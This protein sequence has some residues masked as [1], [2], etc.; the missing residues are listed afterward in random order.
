MPD[1]SSDQPSAAGAPLWAARVALAFVVLALAALVVVPMLMQQYVTPRREQAELA[2]SARTLVN[3]VQFA[4]A[5]EMS[6]LLGASVSGPDARYRSIYNDAWQRERS[7]YAK[8]DSLASNLSTPARQALA[9]LEERSELWHER[10]NEEAVLRQEAP[11]RRGLVG[12]ELEVFESALLAAGEL[13][14]AI[15]DAAQERRQDIR[16][17]EVFEERVSAAMAAFALL[18]AMTVGWFASRMR[19][20]AREAALRGAQAERALTETKRMAQSR[21]RIMRGIT[22]DLK[23][24][25]GAADGYGD[26]LQMGIAGE[27][28]PEQARMVDGM[29][30]SIATALALIAD[31][32]QFERADA[33]TL[34][35]ART[36]VDC[37]ALARGAAEQ[38]RGA[39][40]AAGLELSVE[41]PGSA[42]PAETD[43]AR[44]EQILSNL[45]SNAIKYTPPPG[46]VVVHVRTHE[47][48][49]A[50][51]PGRVEIC[52]SDSG[53]GIAP[54]DRERVFGEFERL[55]GARAEGY[56]LGL[57]TS[58]RVATQLGGDLTVGESEM[59]GA[60][61]SLWL[62]A[63]GTRERAG[64]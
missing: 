12:P 20:L 53:E 54:E 52:V 16:R 33:G 25:L 51:R 40:Q 47:S 8:L 24:P 34:Q 35:L 31:L 21:T 45:L 29:R 60:A 17:A 59:G 6:A 4:L 13:D 63:A 50:G 38:Y 14:R 15:L 41:L 61:F 32:L 27:L 55:P 43:A 10:V 9:R 56:G 36:P 1:R 23:N 19:V 57:A 58:R 64:A 37:T 3:D 7:T 44:V 48:R 22:H 30:R 28:N 26:L 11:A 5:R 42:C 39:A 49:D 62:P 2:D 18:A 46:R